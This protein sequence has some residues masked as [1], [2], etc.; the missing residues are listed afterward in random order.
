MIQNLAHQ[1]EILVF[2]MS[3]AEVLFQNDQ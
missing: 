3:H 1:I 2:R